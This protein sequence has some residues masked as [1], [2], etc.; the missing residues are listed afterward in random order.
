M[1][2]DIILGVL[3]ALGFYIGYSRG[4]IKTVFAVVSLIVAILAAMKLSP[5]MINLIDGFL[6]WDPR[7]IVVLG[8]VLTFIV[9]VIAVRFA[10]KA[11]EKVVT[12]LEINFVNKIIGGAVMSLIFM[13]IFSCF[14]WL[15]DETRLLPS[16]ATATS[17]TYEFVEAV[18]YAISSAGQRVKPFFQ[19]FWNKTAEAMD[20]IREESDQKTD[21]EKEE[22]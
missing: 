22:G 15:L 12:K 5:L 18:P 6:S 16:S 21:S 2:I 10:G 20:K 11:F 19:S 7:L 13:A 1:Y 8:F 9:V 17:V 14:V 4:I 3:M